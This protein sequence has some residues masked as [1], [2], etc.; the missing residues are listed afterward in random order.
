[1]LG[2][3][4]KNLG[5]KKDTYHKLAATD[6]KRYAADM[7]AYTPATGAASVPNAPIIAS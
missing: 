3:D 5:I 4:W 1:M 6:N 7:A 2:E